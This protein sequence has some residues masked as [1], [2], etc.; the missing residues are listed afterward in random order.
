LASYIGDELG[1]KMLSDF[2]DKEDLNLRLFLVEL[3]RC[4]QNKADEALTSAIISI[5]F[6]DQNTFDSLNTLLL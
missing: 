1:Q 4:I 6:R 2:S 3:Q 5:E